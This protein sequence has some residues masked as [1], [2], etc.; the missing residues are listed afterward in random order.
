MFLRGSQITDSS[1]NLQC[2]LWYVSYS[3]PSVLK[4]SYPWLSGVTIA[5]NTQLAPS[6][7]ISL[8]QKETC[9]P[10]LCPLLRETLIQCSVW[11]TRRYEGKY[12]SHY[13]RY[14]GRLCQLSNSVWD[15]LKPLFK[16]IPVQL[17]FFLL[18]FLLLS[19]FTGVILENIP[20]MKISTSKSVS[21][22]PN[23]GSWCQ[24]WYNK[25]LKTVLSAGS[26]A[27]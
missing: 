3:H 23:L 8:S 4:Y 6:T 24:E 21:R 13:L 17:C 22:E 9:Q 10:S 2:M 14:S 5:A 16:G 1:H 26:P 25:D 18:Q 7:E 20:C 19:H 12:P 27:G 15:Q 11:S